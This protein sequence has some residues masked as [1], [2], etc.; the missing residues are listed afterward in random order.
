MWRSRVVSL[1]VLVV[2]GCRAE[3]KEASKAT[4]PAPRASVAAQSSVV[5][6]PPPALD[7]KRSL[8][9]VLFTRRSERQFDS[10][11]LPLGELGQLA[12]A[13]QGITEPHH[14]LRTTPSAGGLYPLELRFVTAEGVF[15]YVP[16]GHAFAREQL[17]DRRDALGRGALDQLSVMTAPLTVAITSVTSRT[18]AKYGDRA[19]RYATLEAGHA[20][21]NILLQATSHGLSAVPIGAFDDGEVSRVLLLRQEEEPL[22]LVAVGYPASR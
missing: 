10:R 20:A 22:Y 15:H 4:S 14:G 11:P 16:T 1:V 3:G 19:R 2:L 5:T 7:G 9:S 18:E 21:Q 13:A 6:L 12:W 8:E 17:G